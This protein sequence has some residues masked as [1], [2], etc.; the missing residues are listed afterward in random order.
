MKTTFVSTQAVTNAIQQSIRQTQQRMIDAQVEVSTGRH[1]DVG[2]TLGYRTGQ[3][4]SLRVEFSRLTTIMETNSVISTR[5]DTG[6][7]ALQGIVDT[8]QEFLGQLFGARDSVSG[9]SVLQRV[10]QNALATLGDLMNSAVD[11][12]FIFAGV[13][14]DVKPVEDYFGSTVP[15][16]RQSLADAFTAEFG[17]SQSDPAVADITSAEM[18]TFLNGAFSTVFGEANWT[19]NW[20]SAS[21]DS[22]RSRISTREL[23][24][25]S[26]TA[27]EEAFRTL[28]SAFTMLA[29]LGVEN[30]NDSAFE[31]IVD[32]AVA[33]VTNAISGLSQLQGRLG[34]VQERVSSANERM[35][36]TK[37]IMTRQINNFEMVDPY[38]AATRVNSLATQLETSYAVT[39]RIQNLSLLNYL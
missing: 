8:A 7:A 4:V 35:S 22:I 31:T 2:R 12:E 14:V 37:D 38:E 20:S 13:N 17:I 15:A 33:I 32:K 19:A 30:L 34:S 26:I 36:M 18:D 16:S 3:T 21:Q 9:A 25:T 1:A 10:A 24:D 29:D 23:I 11:G 39:A 27:N 28:A 6:Q 5:L